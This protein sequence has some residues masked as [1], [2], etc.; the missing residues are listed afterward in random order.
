[1]GFEPTTHRDLVGYSN[2]WGTGDSMVSKGEMWVFVWNRITR[3]HSQMM[4]WRI[5][6]H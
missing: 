1:M 5:W 4:S 2:H 6:P 3:P